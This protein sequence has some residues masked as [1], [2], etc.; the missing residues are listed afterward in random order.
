M[1]NHTK[2]Y[3]ET[4]IIWNEIIQGNKRAFHRLFTEQYRSLMIFGLGIKMD[5]ALV[6]DMIQ[7]LF[8]ELW[9]KRASL[10]PVENLNAYLK[11][12][13]KRKIFKSIQKSKKINGLSFFSN[14][15][16]AHPY[17]AL[18]IE[19]E[20][21][22]QRQSQLRNAFKELTQ[23]QKE[24]IQLRFFKGLSYEEIARQSGTQKRTIYNQVHSAILVLKKYI[25]K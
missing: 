6:E 12:I 10:P 13:L 23:R 25:S 20:T 18:L 9:K 15:D 4:S 14:K 17:E 1:L 8:L 2:Q 22:R 19:Q 3:I 7:E 21:N 16:H 5:K 24:I 11:Q